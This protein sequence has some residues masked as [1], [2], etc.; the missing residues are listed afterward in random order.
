[1]A[2]GLQK[3]QHTR[4]L[5]WFVLAAALTSLGPMQGSAGAS[6]VSDQCLAANAQVSLG[7]GLP[8]VRGRLRAGEP[9]TIVAFGSSSTTGAGSWSPQSA[10][11]EVMKRQL[12]AAWP[13][14]AI[15]LVNAGQNFDTVPGNVR[16]LKDDVLSHRPDLVIWQLGTNDVVWRGVGDDTKDL[17]TTA[18]RALKAAGSDVILMDLQYSPVIL[19]IPRHSRMQ[20]MIAEVAAAERVGL[21]SRFAMMKKAVDAGVPLMSLVSWD[22]LHMTGAGYE[23]VGRALANIISAAARAK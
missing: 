22:G 9:L 18:V 14:S 15:K 21:L 6:E 12:V 11:P 3:G 10:F 4:R 19:A 1:M 16:R 23:C 20:Q 5:L 13:R 7:N 17:I 8:R 2:S